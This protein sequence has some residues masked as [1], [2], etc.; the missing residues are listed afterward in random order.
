MNF[1]SNAL[2]PLPSGNLESTMRSQPERGI[3][4]SGVGMCRLTLLAFVYVKDMISRQDILF[5]GTVQ[6]KKKET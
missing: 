3:T 1:L 4:K 5:N 2:L 6:T